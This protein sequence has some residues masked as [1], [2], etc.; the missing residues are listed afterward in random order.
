MHGIEEPLFDHIADCW[1]RFDI[2]CLRQDTRKS[3][4][5]LGRRAPPHVEEPLLTGT[6]RHRTR[7]R[8]VAYRDVERHRTRGRAVAHRDI[9]RHRRHVEVIAHQDES[10]QVIVNT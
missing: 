10:E 1:P 6:S 7:G 5:P 9:E 2:E 3:R 8:A 4:C